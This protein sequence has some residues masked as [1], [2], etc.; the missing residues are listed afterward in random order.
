M[1]PETT[2]TI[3]ATRQTMD[4]YLQALVSG[5]D[6]AQYFTDDVRWVTIESGEQ[7][8]GRAAVADLIGSM[9]TLLFDAHPVVKSVVIGEGIVGAEFDFVGTN[10][11][12][13]EGVAATREQLTVPYVVFYDVGDRGI[14]ELRA[15]LPVKKIMAVFRAV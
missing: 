9:H 14:S 13:F 6:F 3:D 8:V 1:S 4:A 15:Y 10:T 11:G 7:V 5:G 12:D 2:L